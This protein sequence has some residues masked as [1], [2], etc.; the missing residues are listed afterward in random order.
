MP[1][2]NC[3]LS[4]A[5]SL[6]DNIVKTA[7]TSY[8]TFN[9][10]KK[11]DG[12]Y[13][14]NYSQVEIDSAAASAKKNNFEP[15]NITTST[16][17]LYILREIGGIA[18]NAFID[19]R[20]TKYGANKYIKSNVGIEGYSIDLGYMFIKK[21]LENILDNKDLYMQGICNAIFTI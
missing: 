8:S 9:V 18:T 7:N 11:D 15:Y 21:D 13:V 20:N 16:P 2:G 4:F 1:L 12:V 10:Y 6:A 19:G 5:K 17:Y 3:D 14:H